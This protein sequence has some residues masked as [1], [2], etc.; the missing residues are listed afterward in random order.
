[1]ELVEDINLHEI[2]GIAMLI[3][4]HSPVLGRDDTDL[5]ILLD[6]EDIFTGN[7]EHWN[8]RDLI[9]GSIDFGTR[10]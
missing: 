10:W 5:W 1:M 8:V 9:P 4:P 6:F 2:I 3:G 7:W